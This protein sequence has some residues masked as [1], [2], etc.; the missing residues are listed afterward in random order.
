MLA[1]AEYEAAAQYLAAL[2]RNRL[3][4]ELAEEEAEGLRYSRQ[5]MP[6]VSRLSDEDM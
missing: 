1:R 4:A 5:L 3:Y 2:E 6:E